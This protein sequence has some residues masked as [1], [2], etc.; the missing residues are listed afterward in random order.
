MRLMQSEVGQGHEVGLKLSL[1]SSPLNGRSIKVGSAVSAR[2]CQTVIQPAV[3]PQW[4][5]CGVSFH[6]L[7]L[8]LV[9]YLS[10]FSLLR[11][12]QQSTQSLKITQREFQKAHKTQRRFQNTHETQPLEDTVQTF[13]GRKVS[14][15]WYPNPSL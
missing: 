2:L 11:L 15:P 6:R 9:S 14:E 1:I 8:I 7:A 10:R 5:F 12:S 3:L 13:T 4:T